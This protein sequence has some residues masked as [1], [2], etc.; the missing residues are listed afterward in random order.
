MNRVGAGP[1]P[2]GCSCCHRW[3]PPSVTF[4][5]VVFCADCRPP[6]VDVYHEDLITGPWPPPILAMEWVCPHLSG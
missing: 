4:G 2:E 6:D 1:E 3:L 5:V